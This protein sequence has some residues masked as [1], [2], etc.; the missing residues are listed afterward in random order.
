[1]KIKFRYKVI[2]IDRPALEGTNTKV[3]VNERIYLDS[4][5]SSKP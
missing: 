1:M 2:G 3:I 5:S 4:Y